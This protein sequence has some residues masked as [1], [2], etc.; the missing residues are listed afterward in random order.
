MIVLASSQQ[1]AVILILHIYSIRARCTTNV[2]GGYEL[3][4]CNA[5]KESGRIKL[6]FV[7]GYPAYASEFYVYIDSSTFSCNVETVYPVADLGQKKYNTITSQKLTIDKENYKPG[8]I[9]KG[10]IKMTFVETV[11]LSNKET[12]RTKL[13][14]KGYFKTQ[15][16]N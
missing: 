5:K 10:Y 13:F 3:R 9:I 8:D 15:L 16:S 12:Y 4:Y 6:T 2:Q 7:D 1:M 14:F 11:I